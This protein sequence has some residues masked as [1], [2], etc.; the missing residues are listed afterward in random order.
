MFCQIMPCLVYMV[1][2][3]CVLGKYVSYQLV[4]HKVRTRNIRFG[5][6]TLKQVSYAN[7]FGEALDPGIRPSVLIK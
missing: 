5:N 7:G 1:Y 3:L 2:L 6:I 4:L